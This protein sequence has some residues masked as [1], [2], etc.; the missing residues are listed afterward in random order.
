MMW[1][2]ICSFKNITLIL[3]M[4]TIIVTIIIIIMMIISEEYRC[5]TKITINKM[6]LDVSTICSGYC[7]LAC[8]INEY[9]SI[10]PDLVRLQ[11]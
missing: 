7:D 5:K 4:K 10:Y 8:F 2:S 9:Y 6:P 11:L 3:M 1:E